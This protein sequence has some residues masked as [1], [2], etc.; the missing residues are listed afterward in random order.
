MPPTPTPAPGAITVS[1]PRRDTLTSITN[2]LSSPN[3]VFFNSAASDRSSLVKRQRKAKVWPPLP[4]SAK[5]PDIPENDDD[6]TNLPP[7]DEVCITLPDLGL[8]A[9]KSS[10]LPTTTERLESEQALPVRTD[11]APAN[12]K[13]LKPLRLVRSFT[14]TLPPPPSDSVVKV[15]NL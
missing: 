5:H 14:H 2:S 1:L 15:C 6:T 4:P 7:L 11:S 8:N 10:T 3:N 9:T 12:G 13:G